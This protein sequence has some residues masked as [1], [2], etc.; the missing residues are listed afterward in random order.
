MIPLIRSVLITI[1]TT[2]WG[3]ET[4]RLIWNSTAGSGWECDTISTCQSHG[5]EA[6]APAM[7]NPKFVAIQN[8]SLGSGNWSLQASSPAIN[9]GIDLSISFSTDILGNTRTGNWDI[10]AYQRKKIK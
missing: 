2:V 5:M 10:G 7:G 4:H 6:H 3:G 8:G 9:A 1:A